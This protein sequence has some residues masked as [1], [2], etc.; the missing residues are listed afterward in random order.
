MKTTNNVQKTRIQR[1]TTIS[2]AAVLTLAFLSTSGKSKDSVKQELTNNF[3]ENSIKI[4]AQQ[5]NKSDASFALVKAF[6]MPHSFQTKGSLET[7]RIEDESEETLKIESWMIT[8]EIFAQTDVLQS[9]DHD[10]TLQM[11]SWMT[12]K[13]IWE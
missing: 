13:N 10:K 4:R 3:A 1:I 9:D 2:I 5:V 12:D 7:I 8:N 11:E 6:E